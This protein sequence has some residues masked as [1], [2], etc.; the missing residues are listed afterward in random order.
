MAD[1]RFIRYEYSILTPSLLVETNLDY[2]NISRLKAVGTYH[3]ATLPLSDGFVT[4]TPCDGVLYSKVRDGELSKN[5]VILSR[6]NSFPETPIM[7]SLPRSPESIVSDSDSVRIS[8]DG[9]VGFLMLTF[10]SGI[11]LHKTEDLTED[12]YRETVKKSLVLHSAS[13]TRPIVCEE[14]FKIDN[15]RVKIIDKFSYRLFEDSKATPHLYLSPLP[16][17][18]TLATEGNSMIEVDKRAKSDPHPTKYRPHP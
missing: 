17:A 8:F 13:V 3:S 18:L 9:E 11:S 10:V 14:Y 6:Q 2:V 4:K 15:N 5:F 1:D 12:F 7:L 16:P